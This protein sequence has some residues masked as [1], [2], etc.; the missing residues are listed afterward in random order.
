MPRR[1]AI[2]A[3]A[4]LAACST[5]VAPE[6]D[7]QGGSLE[8]LGLDTPI[9]LLGAPIDVGTDRSFPFK[10]FCFEF[11]ASVVAL[12]TN[13]S[14]RSAHRNCGSISSVPLPG[15]DRQVTFAF[16]DRPLSGTTI[17]L[18]VAPNGIAR[19]LRVDG[20]PVTPDEQANL[21]SLGERLVQ[22]QHL[23]GATLSR[24]SQGQ[25]IEASAAISMPGVTTDPPEMT[26]TCIV[27]GRSTAAG[28]E[29]VLLAC[30]ATHVGRTLA[31]SNG[32]ILD[33]TTQMRNLVAVDVVSGRIARRSSVASLSGTATLPRSSNSTDMHMTIVDLVRFE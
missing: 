33:G 31:A 21:R 11:T 3:L 9:T 30:A 10:R 28:R 12:Q 32:M 4:I 25:I 16:E 2:I 23:P 26:T 6:L 1:L 7:Q 15:G 17:T 18:E 5:A 20:A 14:T 13:R 24:L 19:S 8:A 22:V 29:I 27:R